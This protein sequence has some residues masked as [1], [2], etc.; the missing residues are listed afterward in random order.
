MWSATTSGQSCLTIGGKDAES[1]ILE[2]PPQMTAHDL[3]ILFTFIGINPDAHKFAS[4]FDDFWIA[5]QTVPRCRVTGS[6][7]TGH[8]TTL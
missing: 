5:E 6:E 8:S 2:A 4:C 3:L 1:C 7:N